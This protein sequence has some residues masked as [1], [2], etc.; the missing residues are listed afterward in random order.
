MVGFLGSIET[1]FYV[2][3]IQAVEREL[4]KNGYQLLVGTSVHDI[5]K[6][7]DYLETL[8]GSCVSGIIMTPFLEERD[9]GISDLAKRGIPVIQLFRNPYDDL[10]S[11]LMDDE[12]GAYLA[13]K[14]L[15][16]KGHS[17]DPPVRYSGFLRART[18]RR[19]QAGFSGNGETGGRQFD[20][21]HQ[22]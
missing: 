19:I 2:N 22:Q 21:N 13:T 16:E 6:E 1:P 11:V 18:R 3:I 10:D 8:A 7:R 5:E 15:L 14:A 12:K 17:R 20:R 4:Q 9:R